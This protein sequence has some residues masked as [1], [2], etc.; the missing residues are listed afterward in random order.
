MKILVDA[1]ACPVKQKIVSIAQKYNLYVVMIVD[2]SHIFEDSYS[3]III[4]DKAKDSVDIALVN[5]TESQDIV[6]TQDYGVATMALAKGAKAINQNGLIYNEN[7]INQLLMDRHIGGKLRRAGKKT[8]HFK[9]RS[10]DDD[11]KFE[12]AFSKLI[13][14]T[15]EDSV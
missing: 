1:D 2:T 9:K 10:K 7:N 14:E 15:I 11:I 8:V 12:F 13:E 3:D 6:V 4:V 5:K